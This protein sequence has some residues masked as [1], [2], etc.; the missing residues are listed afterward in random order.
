MTVT[1]RRLLLTCILVGLVASA[2]S[3]YVHYQLLIDPNYLSFCDI[4]E[5]VSC[6]QVYLSRYGS[7]W[8]IPVAYLGLVWFALGAILVAGSERGTSVFWENVPAYLFAL[9]TLGLAVVLYLA[10]ASFVQL[11]AVCFLC[12]MVYVAVAGMFLVSGAAAS[13]P[14]T[15][16]PAR[17][18][19]DLRALMASAA[20][21]GVA[22]GFIVAAVAGAVWLSDEAEPT[23]TASI[24][25]ISEEE[26]AEFIRWWEAQP[27]VD[28]PIDDD[29]ATVV[30]V[31]FNDYQCPPCR[32]TYLS[33][34]GV[35]AKY[36][37][38]RP[39]AVRLI[40]KH[41]P[42]DPECNQDAP[43][44]IHRAACEAA[45]AVNLA[46]RTGQAERMEAWLFDNQATLSPASVRAA[47]RDVAGIEDFDEEY[48]GMLETIRADIALGTSLSIEATPTFVIN[49]VRVTGGLT[50]PYFDAAIAYELQ[51]A[52]RT[53]P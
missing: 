40:T 46:R 52:D 15:Q 6:T 38:A 31:K 22:G 43:N 27:R 35:F 26:H 20:A 33:Y 41:F 12:V 11:N 5:T 9:S 50:A 16:L 37:A 36:E 13:F 49:G 4:N 10:Y 19:R 28:L 7:V 29:G 1:Q 42:L 8:G 23:T 45:A 3:V 34:H 39:G 30:V 47:A 25:T 51:Q 18:G 32:Q 21:L 17:A 44:G 14:M 48:P 24:A 2:S 53:E